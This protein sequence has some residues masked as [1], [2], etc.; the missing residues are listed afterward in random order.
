MID[1]ASLNKACRRLGLNPS[2]RGDNNM[3]GIPVGVFKKPF[4]L[5]EIKFPTKEMTQVLMIGQTIS[6]LRSQLPSRNIFDN[7]EESKKNYLKKNAIIKVLPVLNESIG[8][9]FQLGLFK[10]KSDV[11]LILCNGEVYKIDPEYEVREKKMNEQLLKNRHDFIHKSH[12][13]E[14]GAGKVILD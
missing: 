14:I 12:A 4:D 5:G 8:F 6:N 1:Y 10:C 2:I 11:R 3:Q 7:T 13:S 9:W